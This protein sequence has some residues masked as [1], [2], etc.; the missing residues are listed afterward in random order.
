MLLSLMGSNV[1]VTALLVYD[2][3]RHFS[4]SIINWVVAKSPFNMS[5][6]NYI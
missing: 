5:K 4:T 6:C 1:K 3:T 2:R